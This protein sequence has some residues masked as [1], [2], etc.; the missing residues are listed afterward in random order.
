[1][2]SSARIV[3]LRRAPSMSAS[4]PQNPKRSLPASPV[5]RAAL[6]APERSDLRGG[7]PELELPAL[8]AIDVG[9]GLR[10]QRLGNGNGI[11]IRG[12]RDA[13]DQ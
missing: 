4:T 6:A 13:T 10:D 3:V 12:A 9:D 11:A 7:D 2:R 8:G 1:M 5:S